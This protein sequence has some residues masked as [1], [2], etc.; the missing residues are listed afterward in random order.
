MKS[1]L[2]EQVQKNKV[3]IGRNDRQDIPTGHV[4]TKIV[5]TTLKGLNY[6]ATDLALINLTLKKVLAYGK[7]L[8]LTTG[9][10]TAGLVV[11]GDLYTLRHALA[12]LNE[13]EYLS[14][15]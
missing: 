7:E 1:F 3:I 12:D 11:E 6:E 9:G 8:E 2:I 5:K 10:L 14:I 13:N 4:F 15:E